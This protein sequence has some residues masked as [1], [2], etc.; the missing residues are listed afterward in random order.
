[1]VPYSKMALNRMPCFHYEGTVLKLLPP[2]NY[3]RVH[4]HCYGFGCVLVSAVFKS[5]SGSL[6]SLL[7]GH[8]PSIPSYRGLP[9]EL[10]VTQHLC[11][12]RLRGS[13][14][15][16]WGLWRDSAFSLSHLL[17]GVFFVVCLVCRHCSA[18]FRWVSGDIAS[19][20]AVGS[21]CPREE[22][23]LG[24]TLN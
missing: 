22:A 24:S 17:G 15:Q 4:I 19:Y 2:S 6:L 3:E 20:V 21:G 11:R 5:S 13:P 18:S 10:L 9:P 1:M 16:R 12:P 23:S 8:N 14:P 7:K